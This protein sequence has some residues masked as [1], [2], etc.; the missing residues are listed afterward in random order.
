MAIRIGSRVMM[1]AKA[2]IKGTVLNAT[3]KYTWDIKWDDGK[4]RAPYKS[5]QLKDEPA[6]DAPPAAITIPQGKC[7]I[8]CR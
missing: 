6:K 3:G 7:H 2:A 5:Q 1:K 8:L 4:I